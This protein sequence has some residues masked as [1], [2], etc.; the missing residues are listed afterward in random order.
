MSMSSGNED[1]LTRVVSSSPSKSA[2][3]WR[4]RRRVDES[5]APDG[6]GNAGGGVDFRA[7]A[8]VV[9]L[10]TAVRSSGTAKSCFQRSSDSDHTIT[11]CSASFQTQ[12]FASRS[13]R[14]LNR[15]YHMRASSGASSAADASLAMGMFPF[16][17]CTPHLGLDLDQTPT[18]RSLLCDG[19]PVLQSL[20]PAPLPLVVGGQSP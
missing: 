3:V 9:A 8:E 14:I 5:G 6:A 20:R 7:N 17:D 12:S 15:A 2:T 16:R 1:R 11:S 13:S 10:R 4:W 18:T 19:S